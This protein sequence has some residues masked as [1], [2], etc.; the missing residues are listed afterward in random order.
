[1]AEVDCR[2]MGSLQSYTITYPNPDESPILDPPEALPTSEPAT[3]Q[4]EYTI[5]AGHLPTVTPAGLAY[6]LTAIL[7]AAGQN[8]DAA[9]QTV[10]YRISKN[11]VSVATGSQSV[12][13]GQ[14][15]TW[16]HYN[17]LGIQVGDVLACKLWATSANVSWDYKAIAVMPTRLG[18]GTQ[19]VQNVVATLGTYPNLGAGT[20][21][22]FSNGMLRY[23]DNTQWSTTTLTVSGLVG[24]LLRQGPTYGLLRSHY[25]DYSSSST[26]RTSATDR[27]YYNQNYVPTALSFRPLTIRV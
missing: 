20:P 19:V 8:T 4:I 25:G 17:F 10:Y 18:I 6:T 27:P 12:P 26:I 11:G 16:N 1:M 3:A 9:G 24:V 23:H 14:Y 22:A 5:G 13:A 7:Y 2:Y 21:R 15:Y